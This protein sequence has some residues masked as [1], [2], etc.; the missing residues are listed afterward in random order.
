VIAF[1][2]CRLRTILAALLGREAPAGDHL[3]TSFDRARSMAERQA[4]TRR[5]RTRT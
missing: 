3:E 2:H 4:V 5:R 1:F